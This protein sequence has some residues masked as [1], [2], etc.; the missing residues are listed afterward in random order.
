MHGDHY[1]LPVAVNHRHKIAGV[2]HRVSGTGE[3][4]FVEPAS[5]AN[6][7]A[8]RVSLKAEEDREIRKILRRLSGEVGRIAKPLAY[9]LDVIAKLDL[10]TARAKFGRITNDG[11]DDQ[12]IGAT[13]ASRRPPSSARTSLPPSPDA[14][15]PPRTVVPIE[16][17]LGFGFNMLVV[18][19]PNTGGKTVAGKPPARSA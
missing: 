11:P 19:G 12:R 16:V 10:I 17:R 2:V 6:L 5:I 9:S 3:T 13:L 15:T 4:V 8:E 14:S 18:T 7:S 1:A